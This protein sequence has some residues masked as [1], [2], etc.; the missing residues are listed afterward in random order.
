MSPRRKVLKATPFDVV[1]L[2]WFLR[3]KN[4]LQVIDTWVKHNKTDKDTNNLGDYTWK[5]SRK[6]DQKVSLLEKF[7]G[8][9][10][11]QGNS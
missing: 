11:S 6:L 5:S 1:Y 8:H 2:T 10:E 4:L 7:C 3:H 9:D